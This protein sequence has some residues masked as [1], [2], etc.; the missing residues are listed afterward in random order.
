MGA[1]SLVLNVS[2]TIRG[3]GR[4]VR[5]PTGDW[6]DPPLPVALAA[7]GRGRPV[8]APSQ[9][10]IPVD[11]ADFDA[12]AR[13]VER[14]GIVEGHAGLVGRWLGDRIRVHHQSIELPEGHGPL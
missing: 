2:D 9:Y 5:T 6:F 10:A 4:L 7:G 1:R 14:D 8:R 13:R 3:R 12:V 11:G